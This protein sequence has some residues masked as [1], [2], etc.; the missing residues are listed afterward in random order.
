MEVKIDHPIVEAKQEMK[1]PK[2]PIYKY[3]TRSEPIRIE[4]IDSVKFDNIKTGITDRKDLPLNTQHAYNSW[5]R[6]LKDQL[7]LGDD[8][9][10]IL[11]VKDH[12]LEIIYYIYNSAHIKKDNSLRNHI[13]NLG[14]VLL[15]IDKNK[16]RELVRDYFVEGLKLSK[17]VKD[18]D[19]DNLLGPNEQKNFVTFTELDNKRK[20]L[21]NVWDEEPQNTVSNIDHLILALNTLLPPLRLN[22]V[23]SETVNG[24]K[25]WRNKEAP[26]DNDINYMW[27]KAPGKWY[28]VINKDKNIEHNKEYIK[29]KPNL[30]NVG[31]KRPVFRIS[32]QLPGMDD[33]GKLMNKILSLSIYLFPREWVLPSYLNENRPLTVS[34]YNGILHTLFSPKKPTQ[35]IIRKAFVNH[36]YN[37]NL[38]QNQLTV[39]SKRMRH[40][41]GLARDV[42]QKIN[43]LDKK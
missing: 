18:K 39:L 30:Y 2:I 12:F 11:W 27:E 14:R 42:Y 7:N 34:A 19:K 16:Y 21:Y 5:F 32:E 23:K 1:E 20:H 8:I 31:Y 22:Y 26:P 37:A 9:S 28:L 41:V 43:I 36:F 4:K 40:N 13:E 29:G 10:N 3:R 17:K 33:R 38:S 24:A 6:A 15:A 35:N 25:F